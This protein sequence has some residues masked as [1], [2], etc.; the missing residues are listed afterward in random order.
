MASRRLWESLGEAAYL[1]NPLTEEY[2]LKGVTY[3]VFERGQL[4]WQKN[5]DAWVVPLGEVLAKKYRVS[6]DPVGQ[7]DCR[8]TPRTCSSRRRNRNR[9]KKDQPE[10]NGEKLD[11]DQPQRPVHG[12]LGGHGRR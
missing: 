3:Q 6:M 10:G 8:S 9:K 1:G 12:G 5:K 7:G 11:R 2:V 4:A